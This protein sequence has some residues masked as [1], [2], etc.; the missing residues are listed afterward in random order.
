MGWFGL[1]E[2]EA[3]IVRAVVEM[4]RREGKPTPKSRLD[5]V[6]GDESAPLLRRLLGSFLREGPGDLYYPT[7][8]A[9]ADDP[10]ARREIEGALEAV[11]DFRQ[12]MVE[13]DQPSPG[14]DDVVS[15]LAQHYQ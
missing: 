9:I 2:P 11:I 4:A 13:R 7:L 10:D 5:K 1:T 15:A 14:I 6:I 8:N 12:R 3:K